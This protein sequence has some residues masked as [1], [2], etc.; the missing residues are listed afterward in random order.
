[1]KILKLRVKEKE[2]KYCECGCG[3]VVK[4]RFVHGHN[5][6]GSKRTLEQKKRAS[7]ARIKLL[8]ENPD[9]A[10]KIAKA[11]TGKKRTKEQRS[12]MSVTGKKRFEDPKEIEKSSIAAKK[13]YRDDPTYAV[14]NSEA[15]LKYYRETPGAVEKNSNAIKKAYKDDPTYVVR[16]SD[17]QIKWCNEH[18]EELKEKGIRKSEWIK[19]HPEWI[20]EQSLQKIQWHKDNPNI[21]KQHSKDVIQWYKDNPDK[22]KVINEK[23]YK[24][25]GDQ[26]NRNVHSGRI[27][28][29]FIDNP[30]LAKIHSEIRLE[31]QKD[32]EFKKMMLEANRTKEVREKRSKSISKF[33]MENPEHYNKC[34]K[35]GWYFS[36]KNN[37]EVHY[38]SSYELKAYE[39]LEKKNIIKYEV[40]PIRIPYLYKEIIHNTVPDIL[41]YHKDG[42]KELIEVKARWNLEQDNTKIKLEAMEKYSKEN[43]M[44]FSVWTENE[45]G[46]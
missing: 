36:K 7:E 20:E 27:K 2:V 14:R 23:Q 32:P 16:N 28:Q 29:T 43:N 40:E 46:I 5:G 12:K 26:E 38:R 44:K 42:S 8:K 10:K 11:N 15:K 19:E 30:E 22:V 9:I 31:Q 33:I 41:V 24:Y 35:S 18:P 3:T 13:A 45:L 1:M 21:A 37:K 4:N 17:A 39:I 25:W 34:S 6:R